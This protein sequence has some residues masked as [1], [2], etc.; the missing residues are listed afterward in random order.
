MASS[1]RSTVCEDE[2]KAV[3]VVALHPELLNR[4]A[5]SSYRGIA[6]R[7]SVPP[8]RSSRKGEGHAE[9]P[10]RMLRIIQAQRPLKPQAAGTP[11]F[12]KAGNSKRANLEPRA[13]PVGALSYA[14][15]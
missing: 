1:A 8:S 4:R 13:I 9:G 11:R 6:S 3:H 12:K 14:S 10:S 7:V 15:A 5:A 2:I